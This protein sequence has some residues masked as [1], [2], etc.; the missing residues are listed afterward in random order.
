MSRVYD[1]APRKEIPDKGA[2]FRDTR[3]LLRC[4]PASPNRPGP[5]RHAIMSRLARVAC[6]R[7]LADGRSARAVKRRRTSI[8]PTHGRPFGWLERARRLLSGPGP[9]SPPI[10][11]KTIA[12][13]C[14]RITYG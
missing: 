14:R 4:S 3:L 1:R 13:V 8:A 12:K 6:V 9:P 7:T 10:E 5:V 11:E 2:S